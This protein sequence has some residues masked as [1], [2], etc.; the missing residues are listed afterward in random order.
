[1]IDLLT[2]VMHNLNNFT[3]DENFL[4][5]NPTWDIRIP[6]DDT[7]KMKECDINIIPVEIADP[8]MIG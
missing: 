8:R 2:C 6:S 3:K 1:M 5:T 7:F 4:T